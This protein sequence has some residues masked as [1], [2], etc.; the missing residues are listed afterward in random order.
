MAFV[1]VRTRR[2]DVFMEPEESI[3]YKKALSVSI[4]ANAYLKCYHINAPLR[5]DIIAITG[6]PNTNYTINHIPN[7]FYPPRR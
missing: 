7:A 1:E 4:A 3:N 2:N 5:F 6:T